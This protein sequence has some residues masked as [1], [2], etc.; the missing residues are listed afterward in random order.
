MCQ[1]IPIAAFGTDTLQTDASILFPSDY[2]ARDKKDQQKRLASV[3]AKD[4]DALVKIVAQLMR[5]ADADELS[6][7][8]ALAVEQE[9]RSF[10][11]KIL[12]LVKKAQTSP[13]KA[14]KEAAPA[15]AA[16]EAARAA[17][18]PRKGSQEASGS[19]PSTYLL[20]HSD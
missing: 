12:K 17:K 1:I 9:A 19:L 14:A 20:L 15:K 16:E 7:D 4:L 18:T 5:Q 8:L 2:N 13:A 3:W 10:Q 11:K 6:K